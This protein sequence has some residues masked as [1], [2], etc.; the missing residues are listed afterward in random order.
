MDKFL[1]SR[2][3]HGGFPVRYQSTPIKINTNV[4]ANALFR[5]SLPSPNHPHFM[6]KG[7][8]SFLFFIFPIEILLALEK[9]HHIAGLQQSKAQVKTFNLRQGRSSEPLSYE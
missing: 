6:W 7:T 4:I 2:V 9:F 5:Q 3:H 8:F 1:L